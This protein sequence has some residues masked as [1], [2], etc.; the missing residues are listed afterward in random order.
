MS[1][2]ELMSGIWW[3]QGTGDKDDRAETGAECR[4]RGVIPYG[5]GDGLRLYN[6]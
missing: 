4:K 2:V 6:P 1:V 3:E 5:K